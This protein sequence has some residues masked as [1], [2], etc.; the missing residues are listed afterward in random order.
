MNM[1]I[2]ACMYDHIPCVCLTHKE[3]RDAGIGMNDG[4]EFSC[5]HCGFHAI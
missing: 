2:F 5:K 4:M 1:G 3:L